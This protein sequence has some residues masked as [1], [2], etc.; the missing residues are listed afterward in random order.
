MARV[1]HDTYYIRRFNTNSNEP[2][3]VKHN[4]LVSSPFRFLIHSKC[5]KN[6]LKPTIRFAIRNAI[7][8]SCD[9]DPDQENVELLRN[10]KGFGQY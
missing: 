6:S 3:S 9:T 2:G 5:Y 8:D 4:S 1:T 7:S 10:N